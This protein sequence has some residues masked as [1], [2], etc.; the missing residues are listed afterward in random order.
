MLN[1]SKFWLRE[2]ASAGPP[3][4]ASRAQ[5]ARAAD[6]DQALRGTLSLEPAARRLSRL[7]DF[8]D[9]TDPEGLHARLARWCESRRGD[10]AWVFDNARDRS[11]R[12]YPERH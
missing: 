4:A 9:P 3:A 5:C 10:Y 11:S 1:S 6:L 7:V 8:L 12:D 2:L